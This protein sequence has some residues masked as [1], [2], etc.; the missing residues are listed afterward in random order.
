[1]SRKTILVVD[2]ERDLVDI[3][4]FNLLRE[5]YRVRTAGDG[6][7]ALSVAE[8]EVPDLILLDLM[9][10]GIGGLE[11]CRRLRANPRT[12]GI[13]IIMLTAK[14][15]ETDAVIGLAQGADDYVRKPFGVKELMARVAAQLRRGRRLADDDEP[16][17]VRWA[18]LII[19]SDRFV[20]MLRDEALPLTTT[21]FKLL[22]HLVARKGRVF[23]RSELLDSVRGADAIAVDRTIDVHVAAVRRKLGEYGQYLMTVRGVGYKFAETPDMA[24]QPGAY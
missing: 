12:T 7:V 13:P 22:R 14:G 6:E 4:E 17:L 23:T 1:M 16:N 2:D 9:L 21:E 3:L 11:V 18:E 15:E 24:T 19:D 5:M 8:R 20:A 10:P